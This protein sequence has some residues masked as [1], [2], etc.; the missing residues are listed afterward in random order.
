[1]LAY[2]AAAAA[3]ATSIMADWMVPLMPLTRMSL[4][5]GTIC[6]SRAATAGIWMPAP[7]ERIAM[8]TKMS[9]RSVAPAAMS[10]AS[11]KVTTAMV[12]SAPM[13]SF[14]RSS[15]SAQTPPNTE[16]TACGRKPNTAYSAM[17]PP[18]LVSRVRCHITAYCTS[19]EPNSE[20]VCPD[21]KMVT[22]RR[23]PGRSR[24]GASAGSVMPAMVSVASDIEHGRFRDGR[25]T[26]HEQV[27]FPL[28]RR[29]G[30][31]A[32]QL[33][34]GLVRTPEPDQHVRAHRAE[35]VVPGEPGVVPDRV[36]R[37]ERRLGTVR[38]QHRDRA[39][40]LDHGRR[41][42]LRERVV[43]RRDGLP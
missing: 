10:M 38:V 9:H 39:V 16:I 42:Q 36:E 3:G 41:C 34:G 32:L 43:E 1:M 18:D 40:E 4:S 26:G 2:T 20:T 17:T 22:S 8:A 12:A 6:G 35:Q 33:L 11:A 23:Q 15:R 30:G 24:A 5:A 13:M 21:R 31:C 25:R 7:A 14:L 29:Q 19:I 27:P 37:R 28:R